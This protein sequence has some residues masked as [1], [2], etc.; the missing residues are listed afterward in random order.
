MKL[1]LRKVYMVLKSLYTIYISWFKK[2]HL[3]SIQTMITAVTFEVP[4][5]FGPKCL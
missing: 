3:I 1:G 2:G 4:L 5:R